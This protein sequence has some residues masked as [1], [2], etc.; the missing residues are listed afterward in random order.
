MRLLEY[1]SLRNIRGSAKKKR[2]EKIKSIDSRVNSNSSLISETASD[3]SVTDIRRS[4]SI[5]DRSALSSSNS[6]DKFI[7]NEQS[8]AGILFI[9]SINNLFLLF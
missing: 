5:E 6:T 1:F 7:Q 8:V 3:A 4:C 9:Y 2:L